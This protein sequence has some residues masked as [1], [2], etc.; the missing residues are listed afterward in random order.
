MKLG[1]VDV[2]NTRKK[3]WTSQ[4]TAGKAGDVTVCS[5]QGHLQDREGQYV[6]GSKL[7]KNNTITFSHQENIWCS[8][9]KINKKEKVIY[10]A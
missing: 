10:K 5:P 7:S 6:T 1:P 2:T 8:S 3:G 9:Q 4:K